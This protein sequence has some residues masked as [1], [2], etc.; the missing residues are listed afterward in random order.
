MTNGIFVIPD[1]KNEERKVD[2]A[3]YNYSI[4]EKGILSNERGETFRITGN[5][6]T[7]QDPTG[8]ATLSFWTGDGWGDVGYSKR[9]GGLPIIA[10]GHDGKLHGGFWNAT[11]KGFKGISALGNRADLL[12]GKNSIISLVKNISNKK[13]IEI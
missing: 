9:M 7:H 10:I 13:K 3:N 1:Y 2:I 12:S 11:D 8:N 4:T 6:Y 5:I